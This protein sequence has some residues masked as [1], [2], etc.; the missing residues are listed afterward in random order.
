MNQE[1]FERK[2][3]EVCEWEW[4]KVQGSAGPQARNLEDGDDPM[5]LVVKRLKPIPCKIN[6]GEVNCDFV[7]KHYEH[8]ARKYLTQRC[9]TCGIVITPKKNV[10]KLDNTATIIKE[11][12]QVE[13]QY[14]SGGYVNLEHVPF[15]VNRVLGERQDNHELVD[16]D[17]HGIITRYQD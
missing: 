6:P 14:P 9:K 8:G 7:I 2:L 4:R 16:E 17:E 10:F 1:E 5:E 3:S 12:H 15:R 13:T 11:V